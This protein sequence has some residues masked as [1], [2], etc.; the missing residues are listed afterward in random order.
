[1]IPLGDDSY[2]VQESDRFSQLLC[3][4]QL[5][6]GRRLVA[7]KA[8]KVGQILQNMYIGMLLNLTHL[9]LILTLIAFQRCV[10]HINCL[11][12]TII[13]L[14]HYLNLTNY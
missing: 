6:V 3:G 14:T 2:L 1:M 8:E 10:K 5:Q 12:Y 11:I 4:L 7:C 9:N 13:L